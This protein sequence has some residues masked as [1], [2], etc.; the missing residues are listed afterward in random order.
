MFSCDT[1]YS[2]AEV[3]EGVLAVEVT[4]EP[5]DLAVPDAKQGRSCL[6]D[7]REIQPAH[8]APPA[9]VVE[10]KYALRIHLAELVRF[11]AEVLERAQEL[12]LALRHPSQSGSG[13]RPGSIGDPVLDFGVCPG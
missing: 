11:D 7:L 5:R 10:Y 1:A 8:F 6:D 12:T 3:G 13:H 2:Q 4:H 9:G